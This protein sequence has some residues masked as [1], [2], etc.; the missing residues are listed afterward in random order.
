M[1]G[2]HLKERTSQRVLRHPL[3]V[4]SIRGLLD[5]YPMGLF[6]SSSKNATLVLLIQRFTESLNAAFILKN[7]ILNML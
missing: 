1:F 3:V 4:H 5:L 6:H 2:K 7:T